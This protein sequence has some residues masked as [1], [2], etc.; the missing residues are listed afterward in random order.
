MAGARVK[1]DELIAS[2][3]D[4]FITIE[5]AESNDVYHGLLTEYVDEGILEKVDR[6][7]YLSSERCY[8]ELV[9]IQRRYRKGIFSFETAL[10][11]HNLTTFLPFRFTMTFPGK[12]NASSFKKG[13]IVVRRSVL[14]LYDLG[15]TKVKTMLGNYVEAYDMERSIC[16]YARGNKGM[17]FVMAESIRKY[18]DSDKADIPK[19]ME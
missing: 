19:L 11:L 5:A 13:E 15:R 16:E 1:L 10:H 6:G 17:D 12:Y 14:E 3:P 18:V 9:A 7:L 4:G 2:S 8:D